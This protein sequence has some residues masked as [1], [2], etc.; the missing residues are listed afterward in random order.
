WS[1]SSV[2]CSPGN[3]QSINNASGFNAMPAGW[4]CA[5]LHQMSEF[6]EAVWFWCS[7]NVIFENNSM[8]HFYEMR[9]DKVS[10]ELQHDP[11][12]YGMSVRCVKD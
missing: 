8:Y 4:Y 2:E 9:R 7:P 5:A 11:A 12:T 10:V 3:N 1:S 6:H